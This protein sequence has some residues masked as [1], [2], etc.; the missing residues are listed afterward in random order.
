M[1][2]K[3][4]EGVLL[5]VCVHVR[6]SLSFNPCLFFFIQ[7][8]NIYFLRPI[9]TAEENQ[10]NVSVK[11]GDTDASAATLL[12]LVFPQ[13]EGRKNNGS[14]ITKESLFGT[15]PPPDGPMLDV[16][17]TLCCIFPALNVAVYTAIV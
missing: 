1:V 8:G 12:R 5:C 13:R 11:Y 6:Q 2:R 10:T 4:S 9:D 3:H 14:I 16:L 17:V 15:L 7:K